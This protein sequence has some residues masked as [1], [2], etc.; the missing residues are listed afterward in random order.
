MHID[1]DLVAASATPLVLGIL[2]DGDLHGYAIL[3]RVGE[4]SGGRMQWTDGMLYPLLHRLER[5]GWVTARWGVSEAGRKRKYYALTESGR[6][7]L[8]QRHAQWDVVADALRQVWD[9]LQAP[10]AE[11][12]A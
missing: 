11:A 9:A 10:A 7:A 12:H 6:E 8:G 2:A 1:K 4:L 5:N 3:K